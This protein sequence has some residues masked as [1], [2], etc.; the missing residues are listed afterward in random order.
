MNPD[1][2]TSEELRAR[3]K[4]FA[5]KNNLDKVAIVCIPSPTDENTA[6]AYLINPDV[7]IRN[8][9][10]VYRNWEI[11][12]KIINFTYDNASV[13]ELISEVSKAEKGKRK[14]SE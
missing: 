11:F 4:L 13:N 2:L 10:I 1:Q 8:T 14:F 6:G 5:S 12:R 7:R 9:V 3:L